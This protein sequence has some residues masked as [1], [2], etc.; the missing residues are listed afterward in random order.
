MIIRVVGFRRNVDFTTK[1]RVTGNDVRIQG[2]SVYYLREKNGVDGLEAAKL[3][4]SDGRV[5]PFKELNKDY[6]VFFNEYGR[7]DLDHVT[8]A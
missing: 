4:V 2:T 6:E 1:D 5:N 8:L 3:F 7:I